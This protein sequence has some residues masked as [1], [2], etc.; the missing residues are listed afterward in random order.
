MK[1]LFGLV[2]G[3]CFLALSPAQAL[4]CLNCGAEL[5]DRSKFCN[6]C[7]VAQSTA[8]QPSESR[9]WVAL[10]KDRPAPA[11]G[12]L[13]HQQF[14]RLI[15]PLEA[16]EPELRISNL[17]SPQ[18]PPLL[19][20]T[21]IPGC[22]TLK[23]NLSRRQITLSRPQA[24]L[25]SLYNERYS[26]ILTWA[27]TLGS[28]R[29]LI[30]PR[31]CQLACLQAHLQAFP[32]DAGLAAVEAIDAVFAKEQQNLMERNE[33]MNDKAGFE[34]PGVA[35]QIRRPEQKGTSDPFRFSLLISSSGR[36]IGDRM[37]VFDQSGTPLGRLEFVEEKEGI[38]HYAGTMSRKQFASPTSRQ[39]QVKYVVKST[40][41]TSWKK[42][43]LR[44]LLLSCL[45]PGDS[46]GFEYEAFHG[47]TPEAPRMRFLQSIDKY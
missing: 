41:S 36:K 22:D 33:M 3:F 11:A 20:R 29:E 44:L 24:R 31:I 15:R 23:R 21:L 42:E 8:V 47:T 10:P 12:V 1:R 26:T 43:N 37:Q 9:S 35:Y 2:A 16:S 40:F 38:R 5:P 19:Q 27:T 7:G 14:I 32:D 46:T 17:Q 28:E 45:R 25:L 6:A 18:I 30:F 34:N 4:F 39:I 13:S